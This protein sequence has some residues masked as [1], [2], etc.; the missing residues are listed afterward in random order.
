MAKAKAKQKNKHS[1]HSRELA[2]LKRIKGQ[3][4]GVE[5]M[6]SEKRYCGD[7]LVQVRA[8]HAGLLS[9]ESSIL[10]THLKGCV[11]DTFRS[12]SKS[13]IENKI[14]EIFRLF[15]NAKSKGVRL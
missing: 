2:K 7:I 8:V 13:E 4:E 12:G 6:I 14:D 15:K 9:V 3:L 1:D 10:E 11:A 5:K